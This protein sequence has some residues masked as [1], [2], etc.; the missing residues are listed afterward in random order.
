MAAVVGQPE[1]V[2]ADARGRT[3]PALLQRPLEQ[4]W[5]GAASRIGVDLFRLTD[6]SGHVWAHDARAGLCCPGEPP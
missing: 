6:Y 2:H 5:Q 3:L 1:Q 4:R